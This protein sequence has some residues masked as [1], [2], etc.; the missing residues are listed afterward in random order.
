MPDKPKSYYDV[1]KFHKLM[2]AELEI[3]IQ[4]SLSSLHGM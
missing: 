4:F 1:G 2:V 3:S